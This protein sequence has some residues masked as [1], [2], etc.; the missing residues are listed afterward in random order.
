MNRN[1]NYIII[2]IFLILAGA[3]GF[4]MK[5]YPTSDISQGFGPAFYPTILLVILLILLVILLIQTVMNKGLENDKS[6]LPEWKQLK[7]PVLILG[8]MI[9]YAILM[10][11]LGFIITGILYLFITMRILKADLIR[12]IIVSVAMIVIVYLLFRYAFKVPLPMGMILGG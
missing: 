10:P 9:L 1:I 11:Y 8:C 6:Q 2:A 3:V 7:R 4:L 5:D 12:S